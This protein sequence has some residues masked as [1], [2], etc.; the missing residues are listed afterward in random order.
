MRALEHLILFKK[1]QAEEQAL[2]LREKAMRRTRFDPDYDHEPVLCRNCGKE[3]ATHVFRCNDC[4]SVL[5][6]GTCGC[7]ACRMPAKRCHGAATTYCGP[8][9]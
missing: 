1:L 5:P 9:N 7:G 3:D 6:A 8:T 4:D 2:A